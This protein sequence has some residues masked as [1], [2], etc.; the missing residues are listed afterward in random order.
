MSTTPTT[1]ET[2]ATVREAVETWGEVLCV[3]SIGRNKVRDALALLECRMGALGRAVDAEVVQ[4]SGDQSWC[5]RCRTRTTQV[6]SP[7]VPHRHAPDCVLADDSEDLADALDLESYAHAQMRQALV[8]ERAAREQAEAEAQRLYVESWGAAVQVAEV[9]ELLEAE[10]FSADVVRLTKA[11]AEQQRVRAEQAERELAKSEQERDEALRKV[12]TE[13]AARERA[14]AG[15]AALLERLGAVE[16]A[17]RAVLRV[18]DTPT[19]FE[20]AAARQQEMGEALS[21]LRGVLGPVSTPPPDTAVADRRNDCT[22]TG[23]CRGAEGLGEGW[24]CAMQAHKAVGH[25]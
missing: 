20:Q 12:S 18:T 7:R 14:E 24:R 19:T 22:C 8:E 23:H 9:R 11:L 15:N 2:F 6:V 13:R 10:V 21:N 25:G 16:L 4:W 3:N 1:A 17:A 5:R